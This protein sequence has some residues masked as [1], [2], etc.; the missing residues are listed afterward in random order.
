MTTNADLFANFATGSIAGGAGGVGTT[1]GSTDPSLVLQAGQGSLFPSPS[2]GASF[3]ALIGVPTGSHE[4]VQVT[5]RSTDTLTITRHQ[6]GTPAAV[7]PVGTPLLAVVTAGNLTNIWNRVQGTVFNVKDYQAKGDGVTDD[8]VAIQA[9][10]IAAQNVG[11]TVYFPIGQYLVSNTLT[12]TTAIHLE[13]A[14]GWGVGDAS[15]ARIFA[16]SAMNAN[17]VAFAPPA[18]TAIVGAVIRN[19]VFDMRNT[20]QTSGSCFEALGAVQCLFDHCHFAN[21]VDRGLRLYQDGSGGTGHHNR[22]VNC[23]F[24]G[25]SSSSG[26]GTGLRLEASDENFVV[27]CDFENNGTNQA[28]S[29]AIYDRSGLQSIIGCTFVNGYRGIKLEGGSSRVIGCIFDGLRLEGVRFNGPDHLVSDCHF[30]NLGINQAADGVVVDNVADCA[31]LSS[32]FEASTSA[33]SA[34]NLTSGFPTGAFIAHNRFSGTF[35]T[36]P[37]N[38]GTGTGHRFSNN[39]GYNPV[40]HLTAQPA[41]PATTV[42]Y[43]NTSN[44]DCTVYISGGTVNAIAI[45]GTATSLTSGMFRVAAGQTITLTYSA[46]PTWQW[47]GE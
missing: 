45:G 44:V 4:I 1:L 9:A 36:G 3:M 29:A 33:Q 27:A 35:S 25:G 40:G 12:I 15:G 5:A 46:A 23:L 20:L 30:Y 16:K 38:P 32:V 26:E 21:P 7:W 24:D 8:T 11:G 2:G 37:I 43:T 19:L 13:G 6:E 14:G 39:I 10:I 28:G 34:V 42:A 17:L 22:V 18:G 41:M 47:F 31:I